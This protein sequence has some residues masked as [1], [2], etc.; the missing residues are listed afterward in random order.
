[1]QDRTL[2]PIIKVVMNPKLEEE[3]GKKTYKILVPV[4]EESALSGGYE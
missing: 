3:Y 2:Y 1:M 4:K